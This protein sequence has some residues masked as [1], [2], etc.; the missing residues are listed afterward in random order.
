MMQSRDPKR[1]IFLIATEESGDRLGSALMK[2]LRQRLGDGVQFVGVG[3]RTMARE[4]DLEKRVSDA[5]PE[6]LSA[7]FKK[8]IDPASIAYFK[9]GDF[10]KAAAK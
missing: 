5:T 8:W 10:K 4:S 1:K 9:A 6:Q 2:V 7:I 3:G